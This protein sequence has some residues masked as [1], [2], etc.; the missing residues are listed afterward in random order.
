MRRTR[1]SLVGIQSSTRETK[2]IVSSSLE[3]VREY[4]E[5]GEQSLNH[6]HSLA[7][8]QITVFTVT[9][10]IMRTRNSGLPATSPWVLLLQS[11]L[12]CHRA[13]YNTQSCLCELLIW[14]ELYREWM[15]SVH[16]FRLPGSG[17]V[18]GGWLWFSLLSHLW[19]ELLYLLQM[20]Y[21]NLDSLNILFFDCIENRISCLNWEW[22]R[23]I[24]RREGVNGKRELVLL[25]W[26]R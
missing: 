10:D 1:E 24:E 18:S 6:T 8:H 25:W 3:W 13:T 9:V 21:Y 2:G 15:Q 26:S 20:F 5:R 7:T 16:W 17:I 11:S 4:G 23:G 19:I 22:E 14:W 12:T